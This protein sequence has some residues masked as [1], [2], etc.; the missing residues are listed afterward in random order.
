MDEKYERP[1]GRVR[2]ELRV[3]VQEILLPDEPT[4]AYPPVRQVR[5]IVGHHVGGE[6]VKVSRNDLGEKG[7]L[8]ACDVDGPRVDPRAQ[9]VEEPGPMGPDQAAPSPVVI[10]RQHHGG[11]ARAE[12]GHD[13][14]V[15]V[16][17]ERN[18]V[19]RP[20][21][22]RVEDVSRDEKSRLRRAR[23]FLLPTER[24]DQHVEEGP[25]AALCGVDVQVGQVKEKRHPR[26]EARAGASRQ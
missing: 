18:R 13:A 23:G 4:G 15:K 16:E 8:A 14:R 21:G 26:E 10:A 19:V 6:A 11:D 17:K 1:P 2:S 25:L 7:S 3:S 9:R 24:L 22:A 12:R 20:V 5:R